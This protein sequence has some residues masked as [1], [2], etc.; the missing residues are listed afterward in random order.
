[1][2]EYVSHSLLQ[3]GREGGEG[4]SLLTASVLGNVAEPNYRLYK[5]ERMVVFH[6]IL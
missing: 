4:G 6:T 2:V 1:M 5:N 3:T